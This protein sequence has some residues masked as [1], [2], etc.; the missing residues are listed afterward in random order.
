VI[1]GSAPVYHTTFSA[2]T[3]R[4]ASVGYDTNGN[5][6][7]A[8]IG[9]FNYSL[10]YDIENRLLSLAPSGY[11]AGA[12]AVYAYGSGNQR[13][14]FGNWQLNG[15][16]WSLG[17]E[18][19]YFYS[20]AGQKLGT[21]KIQLN[22]PPPGYGNPSMSFGQLETR[23]WFGSRLVA[24]NGNP[25][26]PDRLGSNGKYYPYGEDRTGA[27]GN[28]EE[29][30]ATYMRDSISNLDYAMNRYYNNVSGHFLTAERRA[31]HRKTPEAGTVTRI[32]AATRS[33]GLTLSAHAIKVP[34]Q[35]IPSRFVAIRRLS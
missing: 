22:V 12:G 8:V 25:V 4:D 5:Q 29:R 3:N 20:V 1:S 23:V 17:S 27:P 6:A 28:D 16:S 34:T 30:F 33:I 26:V 10:G 32:R 13:V 35:T 14:Y 24:L 18:T 7:T 15:G 19:V 21:Y 9:G 11:T 2:A 31:L